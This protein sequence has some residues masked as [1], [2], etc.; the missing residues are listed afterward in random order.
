MRPFAY[1]RPAGIA[2]ALRAIAETPAP[3]FMAGGTTL[4]DL[5]KLDVMR[6]D[7]IVDIRSIAGEHL[8]SIEIS[9][10]GLRIGALTTMAELA[11]HPQVT[12]DYPVLVESLA[13]AASAQIRNMATLGGNVLQRARCPYFRNTGYDRCNK[14]LPGSGCAA[15]GAADRTNAVLG[16]SDL[17]TAAYPGDW[18]QA[19]IALDA[20]IEVIG[21]N[22][23]RVLPFAQLHRLPEDAPHIETTLAPGDFIAAFLV[24]GGPWPRSR[25]VK[26]RDRQ[27]YAFANASA[28][29]AIV[30]DGAMV[31]DIRIG[32]GGVATVP[33]RARRAEAYLRG[34]RL[35]EA[36]AAACAEVEF[37]GARPGS[38]TA[39]KI[40]LGRAV[41][42]RALLE[43]QALDV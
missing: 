1:A 30:L 28:A 26:I 29:V 43:V 38:Q 5:M 24:P 6:P 10:Q 31:R 11:D 20:A 2:E 39:F 36:S 35:D 42:V 33:W 23:S 16:T 18:A 17:C 25:Y 19:L 40:P 14:R 21:S 13:L 9:P 3:Q 27:S 15:A 8:R 37:A 12:R 41:L 32:L 4:L 34:A 7:T 22:G